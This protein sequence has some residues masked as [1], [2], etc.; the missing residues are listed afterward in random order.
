MK[1]KEFTADNIE[2]LKNMNMLLTKKEKEL[3]ERSKKLFDI[4]E[5]RLTKNG[6]GLDD[7]ELIIAIEYRLPNLRTGYCYN[8]P[9]NTS[10]QDEFSLFGADEDWREGN[11][12]DLGDKWCYLMHSLWGHSSIDASIF[13]IISVDVELHIIEQQFVKTQDYECFC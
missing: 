4:Y 3:L 9:V 8:T 1:Q 5:T 11:M 10:I 6:G 2:F 7:Y 12:P 13:N